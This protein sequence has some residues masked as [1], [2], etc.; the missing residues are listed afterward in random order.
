MTAKEL[1]QSRVNEKAKKQRAQRQIMKLFIVS[2]FI[3]FGT[4]LMVWLIQL[5]QRT[6]IPNIYV[7]GAFIILLSS[8][9]LLLV[10]KAIRKNQLQHAV[11]FIIASILLGLAFGITQIIGWN[12]LIDANQVYRSILIPFSVVHFLHIAVG[13]ILLFV[14]FIRLRNYQVH[15]KAMNFSSNVFYFWHFLGLVWVSFLTLIS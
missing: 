4:L 12:S 9:A 5:G 3:I 11:Y 10:N 7:Q 2:S 8:G 15:S 14:I 13:L 1:I 6:V